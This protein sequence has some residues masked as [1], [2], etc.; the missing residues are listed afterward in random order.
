MNVINHFKEFYLGN[1]L[2]FDLPPVSLPETVKQ[3]VDLEK[4]APSL[5]FRPNEQAIVE[6]LNQL[7]DSCAHRALTSW[8]WSSSLRKL[9]FK[10][11]DS[12]YGSVFEHPELGGWLIKTTSFP[13]KLTWVDGDWGRCNSFKYNNLHRVLL[14]ERMRT[15]SASNGWDITIPE[16]RLFRTPHAAD[17][18]TLHE[19]YYVLSKKVEILSP[20]QS[21]EQISYQTVQ[22][23]RRIA[24]KVCDLIKKTGF[25]D[26]HRGNIAALKDMKNGLKIAI[27]DTEPHGLMKDVSDTSEHDIASFSRCVMAG[28]SKFEHSFGSKFTAFKE[29][30]G[31]AKEELFLGGIERVRQKRQ[32]ALREERFWFIAKIVAS[33]VLPLISLFVLGLALSSSFLGGVGREYEPSIYCGITNNPAYNAMLMHHI[34]NQTY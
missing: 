16:K 4:E 17:S 32:E 1:S 12:K 29:E 28:L 14:A 6:K 5:A 22:E 20:D 21:L 30:I 9:G 31:F 27:I 10:S 3:Y 11:I 2:P 13:N 33:I 18:E 15:E 8:G 26:A 7:I 23:Q 34:Q 19:K 25:A 24:K